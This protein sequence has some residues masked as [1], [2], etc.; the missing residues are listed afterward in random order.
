MMDNQSN[1]IAPMM[2]R[3]AGYSFDNKY[4]VLIGSF[5]VILLFAFQLPKT[6]FDPDTGTWLGDD[7]H[8]FKA[9]QNFLDQY[10]REDFVILG[11]E[12]ENVFSNTGMAQIRDLHQTI[13]ERVPYI[14]SVESLINARAI[15]GTEDEVIA[16]E[17]LQKWPV[18]DA[19][20]QEKKRFAL[21]NPA[22]VN[23][24]VSKDARFATIIIRLDRYANFEPDLAS[25]PDQTDASLFTEDK[26]SEPEKLDMEQ[27]DEVIVSLQ[28]IVDEFEIDGKQTVIAGG[29]MFANSLYHWMI[30]DYTKLILIIMVISITILY[31]I[32]RTL[33]G[34]LAPIVVSTA[35]LVSSFGLMAAMGS[36]IR[37]P[38]LMIPS[39]LFVMAIADSIHIQTIF[40]IVFDWATA[41][42]T[43]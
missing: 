42:S 39:L 13:I 27:F 23:R 7:N 12:N 18:S 20:W 28:T 33:T 36:P 11:I 1:I 41:G 32:F 38:T 25:F 10:G 29:V 8:A 35:T 19:E 22:M 4:K 40:I 43:P 5:L 14:Y 3:W 31:L 37:L 30:G 6:H 16:E 15:Y 21:S 26:S 34:L 9:Y 24:F 2:I 17:L